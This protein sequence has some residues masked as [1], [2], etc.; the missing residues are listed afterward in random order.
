MSSF[1]IKGAKDKFESIGEFVSNIERGGEIA[2]VFHNQIYS[3][4]HHDDKVSISRAYDESTD[5]GFYSV[6]ELLEY[7][8]EGKKIVD[9]ITDLEIC[10][11]QF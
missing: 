2:F 5:Q 4:T 3:I 7:E 10:D 6:G 1:P 9:L 8:I 11:R